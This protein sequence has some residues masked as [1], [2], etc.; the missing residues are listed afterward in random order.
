MKC[1]YCRGPLTK[2]RPPMGKLNRPKHSEQVWRCIV[3]GADTVVASQTPLAHILRP[4]ATAKR[5][6]C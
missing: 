5:S 6:A 2:V 4:S 3:C 1:T